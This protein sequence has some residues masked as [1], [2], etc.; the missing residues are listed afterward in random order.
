MTDRYTP[1]DPKPALNPGHLAIVQSIL[2]THLPENIQIWVFGSRATG[3]AYRGSDLDLA[4]DMGQPLAPDT[5]SALHRAFEDS[6][7]PWKVDIVDMQGIQGQFRQNVLRDRLALVDRP[8][9]TPPDN[10]DPARHVV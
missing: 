4:I 9:H 6:D 5:V 7:L 2:R 1:T 8:P 3:K 10:K